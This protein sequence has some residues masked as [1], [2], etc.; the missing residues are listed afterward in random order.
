MQSGYNNNNIKK[1]F[2]LIEIMLVLGIASGIAFTS[3]GFLSQQY[4]QKTTQRVESYGV[5]PDDNMIKP[6]EVLDIRHIQ[7]YVKAYFKNAPSYSDLNNTD[8]SKIFEP[9][10]NYQTNNFDGSIYIS[11]SDRGPAETKGSAFSI[12]YTNIPKQECIEI[13][14]STS[15]NFYHIEV[16]NKPLSNRNTCYRDVNSITFISI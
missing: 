1:G 13:L 2:T 10:F 12:T 4:N 15:D 16:N 14:E 7:N 3:F 11:S 8:L 9:G 6:V 5:L